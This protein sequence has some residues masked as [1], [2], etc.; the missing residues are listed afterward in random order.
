M[1]TEERILRKLDL[2]T[3]EQEELLAFSALNDVIARF[4]HAISIPLS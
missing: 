4:E 1:T 3:K 2:L